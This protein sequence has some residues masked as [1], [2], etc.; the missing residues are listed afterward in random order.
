[1]LV[2]KNWQRWADQ[3]QRR[4]EEIK[5]DNAELEKTYVDTKQSYNSLSGKKQSVDFRE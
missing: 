5:A 3:F 2:R 4:N 1:M